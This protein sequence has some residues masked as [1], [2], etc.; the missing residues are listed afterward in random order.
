[1]KSGRLILAGALLGAVGWFV[2]RGTRGTVV[3]TAEG[4][5]GGW[6]AGADDFVDVAYKV[7]A[8]IMPGNMEISLAGLN[9]IKKSEGYSATVYTDIAGYPTIGYGHKLTVLER[10]QG[11][12]QVTEAQASTLLASDVAGAEITVNAAVKVA[13][14]QSQFDALVS[15]VYN[16]GGGAFRRSTLLAQLNAGNYSAAAAQFGKWVYAGGKVSS[17]LAARRT[18]EA[19]LF[20][21]QTMVTV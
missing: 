20:N 17:G 18:A 6:M 15:F 21:G 8:A 9:L 14:T 1:M 7:G 4:E 19:N 2:Y 10:A 12:K 5:A 13:L 3:D 11:L 16:V